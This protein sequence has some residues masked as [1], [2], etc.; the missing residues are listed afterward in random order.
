MAA[1][2]LVQVTS[3]LALAGLHV[4]AGDT[5][6]G[7]GD[8]AQV[9]SSAGK[10]RN[11]ISNEETV[12]VLGD[13]FLQSPHFPQSYPRGMSLAWR[14]VAKPGAR[15]RIAFDER[16]GLEEPEHGVCRYDYVDVLDITE[17]ATIPR[18]RW[19]G[20]RVPPGRQVSRSNRVL[21][22]FHSDQ[23]LAAKPGFRLYYSSLA[24]ESLLPIGT[25]PRGSAMVPMRSLPIGTAHESPIATWPDASSKSGPHIPIGTSVGSSGFEDWPKP[26]AGAAFPPGTLP[27]ATEVNENKQGADVVVGQS[28]SKMAT[29]SAGSAGPTMPLEPSLSAESG[30]ANKDVGAEWEIS[31]TLEVLSE[32][33]SAFNTLENLVQYIEPDN[34]QHDLHVLLHSE[35]HRGRSSLSNKRVLLN[36]MR[37]DVLLYSC[38]PRNISVALRSEISRTD[39]VF[40][41]GCV[42]VLRCGGNCSCCSKNCTQCQ[43]VPTQK[44]SKAYKVHDRAL[45]CKCSHAVVVAVAHGSPN[46]YEMSSWNITI[47]VNAPALTV[48]KDESRAASQNNPPFPKTKQIFIHRAIPHPSL[49][50]PF[51]LS[52]PT[53]A[54]Y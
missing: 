10:P 40:W 8:Y 18:G 4:R 23:Y 45:F 6:L 7:H 24:R 44:S 31:Q 26:P 21:I 5:I 51:S 50:T 27:V 16:F 29:F 3:L 34:W 42:L 12:Y 19:C 11:E 43:C 9:M 48:F 38:T 36:Q 52:N 54:L 37:Q 25:M 2:R 49:Q 13:G 47:S 41:P 1:R 28:V 46:L 39:A 53:D 17:G 35:M 15:I 14:L 32:T 33:L 30:V 22:R 20:S